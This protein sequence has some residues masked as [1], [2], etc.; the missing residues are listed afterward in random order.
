MEIWKAIPGTKGYIEISTEGKIRSCLR[1]QFHTLKTQADRKGYRRVRVT[2]EG[3]KHTYKLHRE[4]AKA[5]IPNVNNLPQVN[6]K[7]GNKNNNCV[8]NLEWVSNI[9][10]ARHA[11]ANGL[12]EAVFEA[13]RKANENRKKPIIAFRADD[14]FSCPRYYESIREAEKDIGTRHICSVLKGERTHAKGWTFR[15]AKGGDA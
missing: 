13:S 12:W 2:I 8:S 11:I 7:D 1:G 5:F 6:H 3:I 15:Y 9:E 4:V 10:N 14:K